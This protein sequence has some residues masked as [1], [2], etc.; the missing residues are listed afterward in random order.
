[1]AVPSP[2]RQGVAMN[3]FLEDFTHTPLGKGAIV[4]GIVLA[5]ALA[6]YSLTS[7]LSDSD[8]VR[9][10]REG[11][12]IDATTG[13]PFSYEIEP[14][15]KIPVLAPSGKNTGYPAELCWWTA[16]GKFRSEP[17]PV[18]LN[19][20]VNKPE[21]TYCPDCGRLVSPHSGPPMPGQKPPPTR[22]ESERSESPK[23]EGGT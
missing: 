12:F 19:R 5:L 9:L 15:T 20:Y 13:R 1:M 17:Y 8:A 7:F 18:L 10:S 2:A 11:T 21:P 4:A 3:Q 22:E 6:G 14:G 16:D 23:T